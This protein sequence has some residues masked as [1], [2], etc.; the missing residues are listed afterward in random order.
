MSDSRLAS[1]II[2]NYNYARFLNQAI[3]SALGQTYSNTEVIVVDDGSTDRSREVIAS[4]DV[5]V[6]PVLKEN[7]GMASTYNAGFE[8]SKGEIIFF[9]DSD[10]ILHPT[11]VERALELFEDPKVAKVHWPLWEV[12]EKGQKTG[13]IIPHQDL[14]EGNLREIIINKG[15]DGYL[16]PP[17]SG[18][19]WSRKFLQ[20]VLPMPEPQFRQHADTYLVTLAPIFGV[21]RTISEPQAYYRIHGN[22]DYACKPADEKN[23]RNLEIY[24]HRCLALSKYLKDAGIEKDPEAWK[25]TGTPYEWIKNAYL[26]SE[27]LK[28]IIPKEEAFI[29]VDDTQLASESGKGNFLTDR[30]NIPFLEKNGIYNGPPP[31]NA[32]AI[33]ELERLRRSGANFLVFAWPAFWWLDHYQELGQYLRLEYKCLLENERLVAFDLRR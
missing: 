27:E 6:I 5:H 25:K 18:N 30:F 24:E 33:S 15:P 8:A 32:T 11:A 12:N 21:V 14:V 1:I 28:S 2:D 7:G 19:G 4:Y 17:T 9:L 16:S 31:D 29:L 26:L 13:G 23:R 3:D 22:N 20:K 10:D